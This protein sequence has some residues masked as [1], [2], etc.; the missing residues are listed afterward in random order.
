MKTYNGMVHMNG[1]LMA[2]IDFETTGGRAG[3]HEIIQVAVVPLDA[4]LRPNQELRPF[5]HNIAPKHPERAEKEASVVHGLD[6]ADL[7]LNAP[8]S[9]KVADLLLDW[10]EGLDLPNLKRLV[11]LAHNWAFEAGFGKAWLGNKL[12]EHIFHWHARDGMAFALSLKDRA[13]FAGEEDPFSFVGLG[14]LC[15]RFGIVNENPHDALCDAVAEAEV[16]RAL[17]RYELF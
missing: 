17:L 3:Y 9:E 15:K 10:F 1:N 16:Y 11:P 5:Y 12:F 6:L 8:S 7:M 13:A 4:D 14:A 2:A